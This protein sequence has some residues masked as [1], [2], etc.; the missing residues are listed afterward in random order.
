[1]S[2][3]AW[4]PCSGTEDTLFELGMETERIPLGFHTENGLGLLT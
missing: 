4:A 2:S 1:M 3:A